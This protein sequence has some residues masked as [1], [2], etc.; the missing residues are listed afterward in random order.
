MLRC[1]CSRFGGFRARTRPSL[2]TGRSTKSCSH[3]TAD[4]PTWMK[5]DGWWQRWDG[6]NSWAESSRIT[7]LCEPRG[8]RVRRSADRPP[9]HSWPLPAWSYRTERVLSLEVRG[10]RLKPSAGP[11]QTIKIQIFMRF[12]QLLCWDF[13]WLFIHQKK[14][15]LE[16]FCNLS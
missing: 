2:F 12:R 10:Q 9:Q 16:S 13:Y 3:P 14:I 15:E 11:K 6:R 5:H 4:N 1:L 8:R 7:S